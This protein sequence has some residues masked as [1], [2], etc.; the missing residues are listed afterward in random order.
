[1]PNNATYSAEWIY[2]NTDTI[3]ALHGAVFYEAS[4]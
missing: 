2:E 3:E 4:L 1:M